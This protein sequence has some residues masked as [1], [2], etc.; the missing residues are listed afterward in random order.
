MAILDPRRDPFL[1]GE[2]GQTKLTCIETTPFFQHLHLR[3]YIIY[4]FSFSFFKNYILSLISFCKRKIILL[5]E[6][7]NIFI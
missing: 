7:N 4:P 5:I 6:T 2:A 3:L 1:V